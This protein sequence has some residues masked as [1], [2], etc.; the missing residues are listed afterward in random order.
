MRRKQRGGALVE[1]TA[2]VDLTNIKNGYIETHKT[3]FKNIFNAGN[4]DF[5]TTFEAEEGLSKEALEEAAIQAL[6][7]SDSLIESYMLNLESIDSDTHTIKFK[8]GFTWNSYYR[9][10]NAE[11]GRRRTKRSTKKKPNK[12]KRKTIRGRK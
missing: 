5:S 12:R 10:L 1:Y 3:H 4:N 8:L 11:G 2:I 9:G 6:Y 7:A